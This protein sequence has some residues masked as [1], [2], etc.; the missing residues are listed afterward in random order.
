M[1]FVT[2]GTHEQPFDRL[3]GEI[4]RLV[5]S[6]AIKE[7]VFIQRG[8]GTRAPQHCPSTELVPPAE[9]TR[10]VHAARL[11]VTHGGPGSILLPLSLGKPPIVVPRQ[12]RFGEHVD[13]HQVA[14][15]RRLAALKK[16]VTIEEISLLADAIMGYDVTRQ[17]L[18]SSREDTSV[19]Q[20]VD[21]LERYCASLRLPARPLR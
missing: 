7:D 13:D 11:V 17:G 5:E 8:F 18:V 15:A 12:S 9:M 2:V 16:V 10:Y 21:N 19:R 3:V 6:G 4:D 20:L 1:I 14:F